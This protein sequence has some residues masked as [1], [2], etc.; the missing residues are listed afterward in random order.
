MLPVLGSLVDAFHALVML[1]WILGLPLLF[2]HRYPRVTRAY[3]VFVVTF[4]VLSQASMRL[5]GHCF[6]T[7]LAGMLWE[8]GGAPAGSVPDEWFTVRF[9]RAVFHLTPSHHT[10]DRL[11]ELAVAITAL[12]VLVSMRRIRQA[13]PAGAHLGTHASGL[14]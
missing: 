1:L 13:P 11:A 7:K 8:H 3:A 14:H 9:A 12:G 4:V 2:W 10:I 5:L 6:L